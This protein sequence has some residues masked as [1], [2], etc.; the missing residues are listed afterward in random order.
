MRRLQL[1]ARYTDFSPFPPRRAALVEMAAI[2][3]GKLEERN[4]VRGASAQ[5]IPAA[6]IPR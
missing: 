2:L 4:W 3:Q 1:S 6:R 5:D